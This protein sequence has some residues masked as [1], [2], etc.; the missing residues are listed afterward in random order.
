MSSLIRQEI[1]IKVIRNAPDV[2]VHDKCGTPCKRHQVRYRHA[3]DRGEQVPTLLHIEVA[4]YECPTCDCFWTSEAPG[5]GPRR[6]YTDRARK[7]AVDSVNEDRMP[8]RRVEHRLE[9]DFGLEPVPSTVHNWW[10]EGAEDLCV[11]DYQDHVVAQFSGILCIDEVYDKEWAILVATDPLQNRPVA[12]QMGRTA[13]AGDVERFCKGLTAL[14]VVPEL[15]VTDESNLYPEVLARVW[16]HGRHALCRF[17][18]T[19]HVT[20]AATEAAKEIQ[21]E[22]PEPKKHRRGRP[23]D[24]EDRSEDEAKRSARGKVWKGRRL[25]ARRTETMTDDEKEHLVELLSL[26]PDLAPIRT[27]MEEWYALLGDD[28]APRTARKRRDR[29]VDTWS[30][31][32]HD[33]IRKIAA[34]LATDSFFERLIA[35][36]YYQNADRTSNHVERENREFRKRQKGHYRMRSER[37]IRGLL[38]TQLTRTPAPSSSEKLRYRF[39]AVAGQP[40][41]TARGG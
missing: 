21:R 23:R 10:R 19:R 30:D 35:P 18:A 20:R 13:N 4:S 1:E 9:R 37:S 14:G 7:L 36:H 26:A 17:H 2:L 39:G 3:W 22:M 24:G 5:V 25:L 31:S 8:I 38:D 16:K 28:P 40:V 27:F 33:G 29:F 34:K 12:Y 32:R 41:Q 15:V 11:E 6:R